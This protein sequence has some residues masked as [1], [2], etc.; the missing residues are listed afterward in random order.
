MCI[1]GATE[2]FITEGKLKRVKSYY[3]FVCLKQK[4]CCVKWTRR[5]TAVFPFT[6]SHAHYV[7]NTEYIVPPMSG[8]T[9]SLYYQ[10]QM[11][12]DYSSSQNAEIHII[13]LQSGTKYIYTSSDRRMLICSQI[14]ILRCHYTKTEVI[15]DWVISLYKSR[16]VWHARSQG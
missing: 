13:Q 2:T 12:V 15:L 7:S 6:Y 1:D 4:K 3:R 9:F 8:I 5:D 11:S 14:T 10:R 16:P